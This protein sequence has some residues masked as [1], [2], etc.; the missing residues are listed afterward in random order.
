M[1]TPTANPNP[2]V[3]RRIGAFLS[4]RLVA[5]YSAPTT[6]GTNVVFPCWVA[7]VLNRASAKRLTGGRWY[8][9]PPPASA[10]GTN[11][12]RLRV[13]VTL[14]YVAQSPTNVLQYPVPTTL[15]NTTERQYAPPPKTTYGVKLP[16]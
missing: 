6:M 12:V 16:R 13:A 8:R 5:Q 3:L 15:S 11:W 7:M 10:P 1:P 14:P 2:R 9:K 4:T